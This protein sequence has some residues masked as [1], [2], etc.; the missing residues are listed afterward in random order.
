MQDKVTLSIVMPV[1]NHPTE[2]KVMIDSIL[3][4]KYKDW[5]LLA[6]DDG[7]DKETLDLL[8]DYETLDARVRLIRRSRSPKGAQTCRNIGIE[9]ARGEFIV[10][11]DSDDF[12]QPFCLEQRVK[13]LQ[14]HPEYDFM[15]FRNGVWQDNR[16]HNSYPICIFGY[17]I[18]KDDI[19][20]FCRRT[21][22]FVVWS[23]IY[24]RQ[25]IIDHHIQWDIHLLSLQDA[26][27]NLECIL[28]DMRYGYSECPAD[29]GYRIG[30]T[31]SI[32]K[33]IQDQSHRLSHEHTIHEFYRLVRAKYGHKYDLALWIGKQYIRN[34]QMQGLIQRRFV[35]FFYLLW[36]S[37]MERIWIPRNI[38]RIIS[39]S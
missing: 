1:Y 37:Y 20:A 25:S 14:L 7:S 30:T 31:D 9:M 34:K 15:V 4:N 26:Q 11:F 10:F 12:V 32:S 39:L 17:P 24:R 22:P 23:N 16:F 6:I 19:R 18:Y 5:E 8:N 33:N 38:K 35:L 3:A 2:L 27:F 13:E 29:Y 28:S 36:V 21:L